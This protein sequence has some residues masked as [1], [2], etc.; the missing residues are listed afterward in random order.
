MS[1]DALRKS[2]M[3]P[4]RRT[5][6]MSRRAPLSRATIP[7]VPTH[8]ADPGTSSSMPRDAKPAASRA[9]VAESAPTTRRRDE[10]TRA[11]T[12]VGRMIVYKPVTIGMPAIDV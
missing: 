7:A 12:I 10:P 11:K 6:A 4:S 9:A 5:R 2:P 1:T 3:K 8:S